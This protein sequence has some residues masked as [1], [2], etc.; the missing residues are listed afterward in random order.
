MNSE[1]QSCYSFCELSSEALTYLL[2]TLRTASQLSAQFGRRF[3]CLICNTLW[4]KCFA[5]LSSNRS[6][7]K[8]QLIWRSV[9]R[10]F[11]L[12]LKTE[13]SLTVL[14]VWLFFDSTHEL[15]KI[16]FKILIKSLNLE[17]KKQDFSLGK[18]RY[19]LKHGFKSFCKRFCTLLSLKQNSWLKPFLPKEAI[20]SS[21]ITIIH[22]LS[23]NI[24]VQ[25]ISIR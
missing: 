4:K 3:L 9:Y 14:K 18:E 15:H 21:D 24:R 16:S 6:Q 10:V 23:S 20:I 13:H 8:V 2:M 17:N 22:S 1:Y 25:R 5:F 7:M 12:F 19:K 11:Q